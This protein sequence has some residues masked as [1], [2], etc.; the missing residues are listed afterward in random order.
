MNSIE[1]LAEPPVACEPLEE[2]VLVEIVRN[3]QVRNVDELVAILEIVDD[4]DLVMTT[5]GERAN[6]VAA[7]E[8]GAA[9]YYKHAAT[10]LRPAGNTSRR[11]TGTL[12]RP[13]QQPG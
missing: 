7:N 5:L 9:G 4:D 12:L 11:N 6:Q 1:P 10:P 13:P 3:R 8:A 2:V